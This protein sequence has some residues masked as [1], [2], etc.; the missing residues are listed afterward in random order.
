[1]TVLRDG[2]AWL[3]VSARS[4]AAMLSLAALSITACSA[5][6]E[7]EPTTDGSTLD[8]P[9]PM[10]G[11]GGAPA[12]GEDVEF[13]DTEAA[14][15]SREIIDLLNAD[16]DVAEDEF[17]DRLS[18][19]TED[20]MSPEELAG[21]LNAQFRPA[22]PWEATDY[23]GEDGEGL[24]RLESDQ[25]ELDLHLALDEDDDSLIQTI[26]FAQP[27][28]ETDPADGFEEITERLEDLPGEVDALVVEDGEPLLQVGNGEPAPLA[29]TS[30]LYVLYAL[31]DAIDEG[32]VSWDDT[33]EVT[34]EVRSL[35][36]GTL[37]DQPEGFETSVLDVAQRMIEISDNTG[38]DMLIDLLGREAIEDAVEDTG[39]HNPDLLKPYLTTREVFQLRWGLPEY[40]DQWAEQNQEER[41]E[42]LDELADEELDISSEDTADDEFDFDL[43]WSATPEDVV[44]VQEALAER[45]DDHP[46]LH[47]ILGTNPGMIGQPNNAWWESLAFKGGSLPGVLTGSWHAVGEDGTERSAVILFHGEET[48][49]LDSEIRPEFFQLGTDAMTQQPSAEE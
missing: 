47:A 26:F 33:L 49:S 28:E 20:E 21:V 13:P 8:A 30:K 2:H 9:T 29:S 22:A 1:M 14:D 18:P 36:G 27:F 4:S 10:D 34:D 41:R 7:V 16:E 19:A 32:E 42:S 38:T 25:A 12:E 24:T 43:D 6:E 3:S 37:Q 45:F 39:H 23:E 5:E 11:G 17:E 31:L 35:P 48:T 15:T 44:A 46:E 40:G